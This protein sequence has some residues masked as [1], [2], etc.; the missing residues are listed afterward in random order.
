MRY[1]PGMADVQS[2]QRSFAILRAIAAEPCGLSEISRRTGLPKSTVARLVA[3]LERE[4]AVERRGDAYLVGATLTRLAAAVTGVEK[5][6]AVA[7]PELRRLISVTH[8]SAGMAVPETTVVRYVVQLS[9]DRPVQV[10]DW[11]GTAAPMHAAASGVM[12]LAH[13]PAVDLAAYLTG[14]LEQLTAHTVAEPDAIAARLEPAR[15]RG[16]AWGHE[17]FVDGLNSV[18]AAVTDDAGAVV[19]AIDLWGPAYRFPGDT[20]EHELGE[21]VAA[22]AAQVSATLGQ[23]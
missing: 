1:S 14:D 7:K 2:L 17:E 19:A 6:I 10:R 16:Y 8:E 12:L 13:M 18:A 21:L 4:G 11:T 23:N 20:S 22:A 9:S 5:L 15:R 3:T